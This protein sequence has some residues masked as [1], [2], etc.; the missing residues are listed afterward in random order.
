MHDEE[1]PGR[2]VSTAE[3]VLS[4]ATDTG[5]GIYHAVGSAA[6]G[7]VE[8][9]VVDNRLRVRGVEGLRIADGSVLPMHASS[10]PAAPIMAIAWIAADFIREEN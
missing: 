8:D 10:N 9:D 1:F 7:S 2:D 6:M 3:E 5:G 4:Y